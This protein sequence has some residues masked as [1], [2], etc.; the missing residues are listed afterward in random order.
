MIVALARYGGLRIP[1]DIRDLRWSDIQ[2]D[3][4]RYV[5]RSPKTEHLEHGG[6][7][8]V[9]IFPELL[10]HLRDAFELAEPGDEFVITHQRLMTNLNTQFRRIIDRAG[11]APWPN[12]FKNLRASRETELLAHHPIHTVAHW[13][14]NTPKVAHEH[15]AMVREED[16]QKALQCPPPTLAEITLPPRADADLVPSKALQKALQQPGTMASMGPHTPR[17]GVDTSRGYG[18]GCVDLAAS[19]AECEAQ[20]LTPAGL[21]PGE[22]RAA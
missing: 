19:G 9:P 16:Y 6:V 20:L 11:V 3:R 8:Q 12:L 13:I 10:P 18:A 22:L 7:R 2:C 4:G 5:V 21:Q 17:S 14:G 15:Y 1:S